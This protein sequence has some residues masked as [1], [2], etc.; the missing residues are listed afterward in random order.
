MNTSPPG[1]K[2]SLRNKSPGNKHLP[3]NKSLGKK[4]LLGN[5]S[6]LGNKS[7]FPLGRYQMSRNK[8]LEIKGPGNE[9]P[10]ERILQKHKSIQI[11]AQ[12][13]FYGKHF[14]VKCIGYPFVRD[15]SPMLMYTFCFHTDKSENIACL[16]ICPQSLFS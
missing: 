12:D 1:N 9:S 3:E 13:S 6:P 8:S 10:C 15:P 2:S 11:T 7:P 5:E 14:D 16:S 4:S